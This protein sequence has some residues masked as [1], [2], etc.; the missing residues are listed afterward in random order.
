[1]P[2]SDVKMTSRDAAKS[3][4]AFPFKTNAP[5]RMGP[6]QWDCFAYPVATPLRYCNEM[7]GVVKPPP[8]QVQ[9]KP[10][11]QSEQK[12]KRLT[13]SKG[14]QKNKGGLKPKQEASQLNR[15]QVNPVNGTN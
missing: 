13:V 3:T 11:R 14:G 12:P 2:P 1:M 8:Y 5:A 6:R 4:S 7:K 15:V 9:R 10:I